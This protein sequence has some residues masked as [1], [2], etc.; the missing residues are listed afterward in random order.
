M[1]INEVTDQIIAA[2][3]KVHRDFRP[4]LFESAYKRG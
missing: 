2:A 3:I 4:R 1:M